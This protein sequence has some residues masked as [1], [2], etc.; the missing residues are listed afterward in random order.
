MVAQTKCL[1]RGSPVA[2]PGVR[3]TIMTYTPQTIH[4][5]GFYTQSFQ[6]IVCRVNNFWAFT[7]H[8]ALHLSFTRT[9][10]AARTAVRSQLR[11][12]GTGTDFDLCPG[13]SLSEQAS[14][15]TLHEG[16]QPLGH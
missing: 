10:L 8:S 15:E 6:V 2:G 14:C 4:T 9:H 12:T 7:F 3:T 13:Q 11:M 5:M 1:Q 16:P